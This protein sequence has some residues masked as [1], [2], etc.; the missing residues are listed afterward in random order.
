MDSYGILGVCRMVATHSDKQKRTE[1]RRRLP[2]FRPSRSRACTART[3]HR[4]SSAMRGAGYDDNAVMMRESWLS[5]PPR[6]RACSM[7]AA[8]APTR[9]TARAENRR[10]RRLG[11]PRAHTKA[12]HKTDLHRNTLRALD[13]PPPPAA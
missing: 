5:R 3:A 13:P 1:P 8:V 2:F 10:F 9:A 7:A 4:E 11:A 6:N 12:P